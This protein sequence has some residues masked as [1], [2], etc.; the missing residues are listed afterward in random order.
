[1]ADFTVIGSGASG[2]HFALTV[3]ERGASVEMIDV[4]WRPEPTVNP[5]DSFS[6]L[7]ETLADPA[8]YFLGTHFEGVLLP[9]K[10]GEFY[11]IPPAKEYAFRPVPQFDIE[12]KNFAPLSSFARGGLAEAWTAGCY[13][14]NE[15]E[16]AEFPFSYAEI[17][18]FYAK[19]A[20]RIG[21]NGEDDDLAVSIPFHAGIQT[22]LNLD[23]HSELLL[24]L[25]RG[26]RRTFQTQLGCR[27]GRARHAVLSRSIGDR[28]ACDY[29]G[30]CLWGC[31]RNSLYTPAATL[32]ECLTYAKF[33]YTPRHYVQYFKYNE[34]RQIEKIV[35][36]SMYD[37]KS[38]EIPVDTLVLAAGT[39][40]SSR[41]LLESVYRESGQ[42]IRLTG[43]MDNR[44]I[45][46]PFLNLLMVGKPYD[47]KSYQ[48]NQLA[49]GF[50]ADEPEHYVH[51]LITTLKTSMIHPIVD[52]IPFDLKTA[53][54]LFKSLHASLGLV[55]VNFHDTRCA[56]NY[57]TLNTTGDPEYPKLEIRYRE[58]G[59]E[60]QRLDATL[61]RLK[62][63]LFRL[64]CFVPPR[65]AHMRPMGASVHYAGTLPM[66]LKSG[67]NW[68]TDSDCRSKDFKNLFVVDG[69]TYP[70]LPAKNTTFTLM[71]NAMRVADR[72]PNR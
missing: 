63:A 10:T 19:V 30:R 8:E 50:D 12:A 9:G 4:G 64:G 68:T 29:L 65:M 41:I 58:P 20:K 53:L 25:Y 54:T 61:N 51:C 46:V 52:K 23:R 32:E 26:K 33:T 11:G 24:S 16:L 56:D 42:A 72:L 62:K 49:M 70:F 40:G 27:I 18:P 43:L 13:P 21:I 34:S 17:E 35:L 22:P 66:T 31:P 1:M 28:Q 5:Q 60:K 15:H 71:A 45:L 6:A 47:E 67:E 44:Q 57:L 39:L 69:S 2:V 37:R 7:K 55:N 14:F 48:Y 59:N 3:L 38:R 36:Q